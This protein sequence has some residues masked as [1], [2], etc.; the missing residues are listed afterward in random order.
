MQDNP[1]TENT[2]PETHEIDIDREDWE[3]AFESLE[4][5]PIKCSNS[6]LTSRSC[7]STLTAY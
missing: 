6:D 7:G 1:N 2:D 5:I 4:K 3:L